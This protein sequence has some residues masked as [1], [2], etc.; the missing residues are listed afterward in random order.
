[1]IGFTRAPN[2]LHVRILWPER[3]DTFSISYNI[4]GATSITHLIQCGRQW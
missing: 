2:G 4:T 3:Y 1:M